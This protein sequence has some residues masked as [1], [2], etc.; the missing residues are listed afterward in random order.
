MRNLIASFCMALCFGIA[1]AQEAPAKKRQSTDTVHSKHTTK[2]STNTRK[3][4]TVSRQGTDQRKGKTVKSKG[5][6]N[7]NT[8]RRDSIGTTP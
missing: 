6:T 3:T 2:K 8:Q 1:S 7:T 4:D 5:N